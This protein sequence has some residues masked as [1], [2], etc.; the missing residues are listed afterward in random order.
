MIND[1]DH[2]AFTTRWS[3]L[4]QA[5]GF[6]SSPSHHNVEKACPRGTS[7][8]PL[9]SHLILPCHH[10]HRCS[11][12]L[13]TCY[14]LLKNHFSNFQHISPC[15]WHFLISGKAF[16]E[17]GRTH[18]SVVRVHVFLHK[19]R[20][21]LCYFTKRCL[22]SVCKR[23]QHECQNSLFLSCASITCSVT[24]SVVTCHSFYHNF[25]LDYS[26]SF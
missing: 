7:I 1:T 10:I 15:P 16:F 24:Y 23:L 6:I 17:S 3:K 8:L 13:R 4:E 20:F 9:S 2:S 12:G 19:L 26:Q 22:E 25:F 18:C 14:L 5:F 11:P 21:P